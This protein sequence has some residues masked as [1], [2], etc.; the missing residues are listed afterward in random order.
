MRYCPWCEP[1]VVHEEGDVQ[2]L[3]EEHDDDDLEEFEDERRRRL[4]ERSEY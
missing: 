2:F 1:D 4:A 3:C